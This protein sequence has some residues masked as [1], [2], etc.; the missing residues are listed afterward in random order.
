VCTYKLTNQD[1]RL[2]ILSKLFTF[3]SI[4]PPSTEAFLGSGGG[5][6]RLCFATNSWNCRMV[7]APRKILSSSPRRYLPSGNH[8]HYK[9]TTVI[10][11]PHTTCN[12]QFDRWE[13][14][15]FML[16]TE[17]WI[18][19]PIDNTDLEVGLLIE[20]KLFPKLEQIATVATLWRVAAMT[21][22]ERSVFATLLARAH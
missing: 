18:F 15:D 13:S 7:L 11:L 10:V 19:R 14:F 4:T 20:C 22:R 12:I 8:G 9:P 1:P 6:L 16:L 21:H 17:R 2:I 5:A 3:N